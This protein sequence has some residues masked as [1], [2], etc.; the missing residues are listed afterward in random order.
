MTSAARARVQ[1]G[2]GTTHW[3]HR[4]IEFVDP[5]GTPWRAIHEVHYVNHLPVAYTEE[6]AV[7]GGEGE[8]ND[9]LRW[10]L[11]RMR[12]ALEK[13]ILVERDFDQA[14]LEH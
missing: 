8:S 13:P 6:P 3:N 2:K 7:V 5:D 11:D 9:G 12:E 10:T 14:K 4:V 1:M